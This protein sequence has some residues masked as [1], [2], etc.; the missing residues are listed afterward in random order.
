MSNTNFKYRRRLQAGEVL[1]DL[2]NLG[3]KFEA[4]INVESNQS[5]GLLDS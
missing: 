2:V 3:R 1:V 4:Q 5:F